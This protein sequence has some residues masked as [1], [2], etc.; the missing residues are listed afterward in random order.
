MAPHAG[1]KINPGNCAGE[2]PCEGLNQLS[3]PQALRLSVAN[4]KVAEKLQA[5]RR[6]IDMISSIRGIR[7]AA[8]ALILI[9]G[10]TPL[11]ASWGAATPQIQAD[12]GGQSPNP[13]IVG[14]FT[15]L[16]VQAQVVGIPPVTGKECTSSDAVIKYT[17]DI[18]PGQWAQYVASPTSPTVSA[19]GICQIG[20]IPTETG[21]NT[22][23]VNCTKPG[24]YIVPI[25]I[26]A[27]WGGGPNSDCGGAATPLDTTLQFNVGMPDFDGALSPSNVNLPV[28]GASSDGGSSQ[29]PVLTLTPLNGFAGTVLLSLSDL[30]KGI[31]GQFSDSAPVLDGTNSQTSSVTLTAG[32]IAVPGT[33]T[34]QLNAEWASDT[35]FI[36][37]YVQP[38]TVTIYSASLI[39]TGP[40][41]TSYHKHGA[42]EPEADVRNADGSIA[43]NTAA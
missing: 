24:Y 23:N 9:G 32:S 27:T 26:T 8:F 29:V 11:S 19:R 31:T 33:Y 15:S 18:T 20:M 14:D 22:I 34:V 7:L 30:P 39:V 16:V 5:L 10:M 35:G 6:M 43:T 4:S 21:T 1:K 38:I 28:G 40:F 42:N 2:P 3:K 12:Y 37:A 25:R 36:I 13:G 41:E 17:W